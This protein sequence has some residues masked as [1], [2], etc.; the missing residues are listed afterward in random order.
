MQIRLWKSL[1]SDS[2]SKLSLILIHCK[3]LKKLHKNVSKICV[4][5]TYQTET[6][7]RDLFQ[8]GTYKQPFSGFK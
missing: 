5:H 3:F 7:Y 8:K 4:C 2:F 1:V 6:K